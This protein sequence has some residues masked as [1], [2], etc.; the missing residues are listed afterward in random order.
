MIS[1]LLPG[2]GSSRLKL[3]RLA[4]LADVVLQ[5]GGLAAFLSWRPFD[6]PS[7]RLVRALRNE[8]LRFNTIIDGGANK[9]QFARAATEMY[10]DAQIIAFEPLPDM[11]DALRRNLED[12]PQVKVMQSAL[13]SREGTIDFYRHRHTVASSALKP[14][15]RERPDDVRPIEVPVCRLDNALQ[16]ILLRPPILLK[17]DLQ[18]FEI[19]A[20]R[21]AVEALSKMDYVLVETSFVPLYA[22]EPDFVDVLDY[23]RGAGFSFLR[24]VDMLRD[25]RGGIVQM[26]ALFAQSYA[27][28]A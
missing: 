9:G 5:P 11:A 17:L 20:L 28:A 15:A 27:A 21:G 4:E 2:T 1:D 18:G 12:R 23:M 24:P 22:G 8:G 14:I 3:H 25:E 26:D 7:F 6:I 13:G 10:P 19:E 16:Q